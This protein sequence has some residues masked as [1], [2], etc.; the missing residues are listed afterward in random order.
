[1]TE[2]LTHTVNPDEEHMSTSE[3]EEMFE[4]QNPE[5]SITST[6]NGRELSPTASL[7]RVAANRV[8]GA[9]E[10][11]ALS[12]HTKEAQEQAFDSYENNIATSKQLDKD[13]NKAYKMNERFESSQARQE[14]LD[15]AKIK[16]RGF[17]R[18]AL[19][20]L[21]NAGMITLGVGLLA[22]E[23]AGRGAKRGAEAAIDGTK[24][25]TTKTADK[26]GDATMSGLGKAENLAETV[27]TKILGVAE[28]VKE[29]RE[30][31]KEA[32]ARRKDEALTRKYERHA[33]WMKFKQP[34]VEKVNGVKN[35]VESSKRTIQATR[36]AGRMALRTFQDTRQ[37]FAQDKNK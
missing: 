24:N 6:E 23:A 3:L 29:A 31:R 34:F 27:G 30:Y 25:V 32:A 9:L 4:A 22:G 35:T 18:S 12:I 11:R 16:V 17:G 13:E 10:Q 2:F 21:K 19:A 36:T 37:A 8:A 14:K 15:E 7:I 26:L 20:H 1:M 28:S 5:E 33:K